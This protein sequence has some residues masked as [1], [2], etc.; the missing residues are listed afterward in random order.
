VSQLFP[1]KARIAAVRS[2]LA[3]L[4]G[5]LVCLIIAIG[6][7]CSARLVA[8]ILMPGAVDQCR[9][10]IVITIWAL[11]LA[12]AQSTMGYALRAAGKDAF[13]TRASF[14]MAVTNIL[15][16]II[17]V[18]RF[19]VLGACWFAL[20]RFGVRALVFLPEFARTFV[21]PL[22]VPGLE[23]DTAILQADVVQ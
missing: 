12:T 18:A 13:L 16:A 15:V 8:R 5:I 2:C 7:H 10:A 17:L 6:L 23:P 9:Q 11:P 4:L 3:V 14:L 20:A 1:R 19:G 21:S 22:C